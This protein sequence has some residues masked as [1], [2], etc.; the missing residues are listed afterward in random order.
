VSAS[1]RSE[2]IPASG[3]ERGEGFPSIPAETVSEPNSRV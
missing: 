1:E 2:D 3:R